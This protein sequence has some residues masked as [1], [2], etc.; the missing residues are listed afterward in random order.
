MGR[1]SRFAADDGHFVG[2]MGRDSGVGHNIG[3]D[4]VPTKPGGLP[5]SVGRAR[6]VDINAFCELHHACREAW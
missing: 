4:C 2:R 5:S 3:C 6:V 1:D